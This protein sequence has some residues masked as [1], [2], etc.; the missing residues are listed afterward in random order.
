MKIPTHKSESGNGLVVT[1][2]VVMTILAILGAAVSYT[3]HLSRISQRSRR[4]ALAMEI[5][6]GHLEY[7]FTN[8]RNIYR[9][10]WTTTSSGGTDDVVLAT[11]Y[12]FTD[13]YN[14][15]SGCSGCATPSPV[16]SM[17]PSAT[18]PQISLPAK[19]NFPTEPNYN[20]TQ[21]RIQAV[22]PMVD[23]DSSENA[24]VETSIGSGTYTSL[25]ASATPPASYGPNMLQTTGKKKTGTS[26]GQHSYYYL[27]AVDVNVPALGTSTGT[28][29]AKVRRIF[30]KT[31]DLPWTYAM[32]YMDDLEFQPTSSLTINGPIQ[33]NAGLYIGTSNFTTTDRVGFGSTYVN[34]FSPNDTYHSGSSTAPNFPTN[35]P[36]SQ[37]SPFLPFGWSLSGSDNYH[38]LIERPPSSGTDTISS[39]RYYNQADYRILID[40]NN[41]VTITDYTGA[42]ITN[43]SEYN[44]ITGAITTNQVIQDN[45]E[46][47]Y[48]RLTTV[49]LSSISSNLN[50]LK[51]WDHTGT[52]G[53]IYI[54]DTSA[55]TSVSTTYS[56]N[57]VTTSKRGIRLKNGS[58]LPSDGTTATSGMT[59]VAENPVYIQGDYNT[60]GTPPSDSGTFTSPT[61]SGYTR[62]DAAVIADAINVLSGAWVDTNSDQS[63][64]KRIATST[65]VN[66]ALVT[67]EVPSASGYY[68]G[69]GE[70][71]VRFLEDWQKNSQTF[72]YYGSMVELFNSQQAIGHWNPSANVAKLPS[73]HWYYDTGYQDSSPPGKL[74][75]AA[76]LQ[77]QRWYQVY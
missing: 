34:G 33:G 43:G 72:T 66:A 6:D 30:S 63:I 42:A 18:P 71:F 74:Q 44:T 19:S 76:Y 77:Q 16:P 23:L 26:N 58:T 45:R 75:M 12:F 5:A 2:S 22:D 32:I 36:P 11:N 15:S 50:K 54:S 47:S 57:T 48:V 70:N 60:G 56:G 49:D 46:N 8:W 35:E 52:G 3:G 37:V 40:V 17:A 38:E 59:L 68:S 24:L 69:G 62:K 28:V 73:Q 1:V 67:G 51:S 4:T 25:S 13:N 9:T 41:N 31:F 55:G 65:T 21:Y 27:A 29:T 61:A 53:I 20:V 7:L 64:S 10:T 39:I 14:P